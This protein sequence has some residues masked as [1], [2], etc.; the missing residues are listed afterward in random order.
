[1]KVKSNF[2]SKK[3]SPAVLKSKI[4]KNFPIE[5]LSILKTNNTPCIKLNMEEKCNIKYIQHF[6]NVFEE[7]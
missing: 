5:K 6:A 3:F 1:M 2:D 7:N 4:W